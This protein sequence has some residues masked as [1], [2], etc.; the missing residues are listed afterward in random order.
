LKLF[1]CHNG[2]ENRTLNRTRQV[3]FWN[4]PTLER[5]KCW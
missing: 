2:F 3:L 5:Y 1:W 4:L